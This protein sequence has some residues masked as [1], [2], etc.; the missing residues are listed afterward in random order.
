MLDLSRIRNWV[1]VSLIA[2]AGIIGILAFSKF[3]GAKRIPLVSPV[4]AGVGTAWKAAA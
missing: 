1:G 3:L 2:M 4:A